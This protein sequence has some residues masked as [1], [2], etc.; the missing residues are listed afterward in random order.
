M[1]VVADDMAQSFICALVASFIT[2]GDSTIAADPVSVDPLK[3]GDRAAKAQVNVFVNGPTGSSKEVLAQYIHKKSSCVE[4]PFV[5]I[6]CAAMPENALLP[7]LQ[8]PAMVFSKRHI[9]VR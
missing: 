7:G 9:A 1:P 8:L 3:L 5:A 4:K 6:N 2:D